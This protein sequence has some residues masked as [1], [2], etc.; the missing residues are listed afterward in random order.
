MRALVSDG[1]V[2]VMGGWACRRLS[3]HFSCQSGLMRLRGASV[4]GR[5]VVMWDAAPQQLSVCRSVSTSLHPLR[6]RRYDITAQHV[7][8]IG[9]ESRTDSYFVSLGELKAPGAPTAK[10]SSLMFKAVLINIL[11]L[12]M[13]QVIVCNVKG[14]SNSKEILGVVSQNHQFASVYSHK[15]WFQPQQLSVFNKKASNIHDKLPVEHQTADKVN[16]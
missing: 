9:S 8:F 2:F 14:I 15:S 13:D 12:T 11:T 5:E 1:E 7:K 3:F 10:C 6:P 4:L 16:D